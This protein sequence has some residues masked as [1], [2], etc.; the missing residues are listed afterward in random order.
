[1][2]VCHLTVLNG[3]SDLIEISCEH[4][5]GFKD[6]SKPQLDPVSGAAVGMS[7]I[8]CHARRVR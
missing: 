3:W 1:M 2:F 8:K 5:N 4:L 7:A 6:G